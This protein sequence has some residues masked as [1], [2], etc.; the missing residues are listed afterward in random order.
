MRSSKNGYVAFLLMLLT[1]IGFLLSGGLL[2][3]QQTVSGAAT[4]KLVDSQIAS[5][6]AKHT[7]QM[8]TL[9]FVSAP[10]KCDPGKNLGGE[11]GIIYAFSPEPGGIAAANGQIKVWYTDEWPVTLGKE[12]DGFAVTPQNSEKKIANPQVGDL[13]AKDTSGFPYYPAIFLTDVTDDESNKSGDAQ[14]GGTGYP[15]SLVYGC[16]KPLGS[17]PP[18]QSNDC[19][20]PSE[21]DQFSSIPQKNLANLGHTE[22]GYQAELIWNVND[23]HLTP[24]RIYRAQFVIHDGDREGDIGLGCANIQLGE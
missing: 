20:L 22:Q 12:S 13:S 10:Q 17:M 4:Y 9:K 11:A 6:S 24:G 3:L 7:L 18:V 8:S 16:W 5:Q 19:S 14:N 15:P 23:L 2:S 21:A 1:A